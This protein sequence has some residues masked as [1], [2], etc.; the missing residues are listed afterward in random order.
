MRKHKVKRSEQFD[1]KKHQSFI[2]ENFKLERDAWV[3]FLGI[4]NE[5][6]K[7]DILLSYVKMIC[8]YNT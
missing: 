3:L 6:N 1:E 7:N 5:I 8:I 4:R 2:G